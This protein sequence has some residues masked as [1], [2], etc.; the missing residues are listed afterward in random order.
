MKERIR[1]TAILIAAMA[2]G[3]VGGLMSQASTKAAAVTKAAPAASKVVR[4]QRFELVDSAGKVR[5]V[6]GIAGGETCLGLYDSAGQSRAFI[7]ES[8]FG[9]SDSA[10]K[11]LIYISGSNLTLYGAGKGATLV[12]GSGIMLGGT[13]GKV[14]GAFCLSKGESVLALYDS[15]EE[16][17]WSAP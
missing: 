9:L 10:G 6:L 4:A 1:V 17:T 3:Y 7:K 14:R 11:A 12:D 13:D 16:V 15:A 5:G 2:A 8:S